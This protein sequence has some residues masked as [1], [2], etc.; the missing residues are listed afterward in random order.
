MP[1]RESPGGNSGTRKCWRAKPPKGVC[2]EIYQANAGH[3]FPDLEAARE[4]VARL[5]GAVF[6]FTGRRPALWLAILALH[7]AR[8]NRPQRNRLV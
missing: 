3:T 5:S 2:W 1:A 7:P 4:V 8:M 6:L